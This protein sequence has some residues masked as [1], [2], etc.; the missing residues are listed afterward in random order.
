[1][2]LI[3]ALLLALVGI[4]YLVEAL[5]GETILPHHRWKRKQISKIFGH[6]RW[7]AVFVMNGIILFVISAVLV[8]YYW[9][10][11]SR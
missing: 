10:Q 9:S 7:R 6:E 3:I 11:G 8:L 1:M 4:V 2:T 5:L